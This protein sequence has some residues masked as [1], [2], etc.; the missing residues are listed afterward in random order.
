MREIQPIKEAKKIKD[1]TEKLK[2]EGDVSQEEADFLYMFWKVFEAQRHAYTTTNEIF[3]RGTFGFPVL[4]SMKYRFGFFEDFTDPVKDAFKEWYKTVSDFTTSGRTGN[5]VTTIPTYIATWIKDEETDKF[6]KCAARSLSGDDRLDEVTGKLVKEIYPRTDRLL[7]LD[8]VVL[9]PMTLSFSRYGLVPRLE[10]KTN[11]LT[12]LYKMSKK[13]EKEDISLEESDKIYVITKFFQAMK[14]PNILRPR[15]RAYGVKEGKKQLDKL[16]KALATWFKTVYEAAKS[17]RTGNFLYT[18]F[19]D[20]FTGLEESATYMKKTLALLPEQFVTARLSGK[21]EFLDLMGILFDSRKNFLLSQRCEVVRQMSEADR[22]ITLEN[23]R[24]VLF[25][26]E[27]AKRGSVNPCV[28]CS[29]GKRT[30]NPFAVKFEYLNRRRIFPSRLFQGEKSKHFV[31]Y[32]KR[33]EEI[34][35]KVFELPNEKLISQFPEL[36]DNSDFAEVLEK[37]LSVLNKLLKQENSIEENGSWADM[38]R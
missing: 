34:I 21:P 4:F 35:K 15:F 17:G 1:L 6:I 26:I 11:D 37:S 32:D 27:S 16:Q 3:G 22:Y 7:T 5:F 10:R 13:L 28:V 12:F 18:V 29:E 33:Y 14:I 9:Y 2:R 20:G 36:S 8:A 23:P 38:S 19:V 30:I 24:G 31:S 25:F